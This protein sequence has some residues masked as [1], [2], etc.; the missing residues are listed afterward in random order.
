MRNS[1]GEPLPLLVRREQLGR[2]AGLDPAAAERREQLDEPEVADE[3]VVV[4]AEPLERDH[5]DRPGADPA[6]AAEPR[7]DDLGVVLAEPLEVERAARA[8]ASVVARDDREPVAAQS[9]AGESRA[10]PSRVATAPPSARRIERSIAA[11]A[12]GLDQL[13]AHRAQ[14]VRG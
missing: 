13:A 8:G 4:A 11:R 9:S 10:R 3:A 1:A 14:R 2:L 7:E 6:L 12:A 5:A